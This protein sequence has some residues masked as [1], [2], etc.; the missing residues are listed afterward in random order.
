LKT[1][2]LPYPI[3]N[4]SLL[5]FDL[6]FVDKNKF[7]ISTVHNLSSF[8]NYHSFPSKIACGS[9]KSA[10]ITSGVLMSADYPSCN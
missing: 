5:N 7:F 1:E 6:F 2:N 10:L 9:G 3:Q 4:P 8:K